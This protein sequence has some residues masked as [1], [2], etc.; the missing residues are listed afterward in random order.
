MMQQWY[1]CPKC[2]QYVQYATNPCPYCGCPMTWGQTQTTQIS[3]D[4]VKTNIRKGE[5][6]SR[7]IGIETPIILRPHEELRIAIPQ[8]NLIESRS[9][10]N[11]KALYGGPSI[12]IAKGLSLRLGGASARSESHD[13]LKTIDTGI[14]TLTTQRV[15]FSGTRQTITIPL[16]K[17]LALEP[18]SLKS[19][20]GVGIRKDDVSKMQYFT[21]SKQI[22]NAFTLNFNVG[23]QQISDTFSGQWLIWM[24]EGAMH[25]NQNT[26]AND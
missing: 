26:K 11:T 25:E 14:F 7:V 1:K 16:V 3:L 8:F 6:F 18:V 13:E 12:R 10:R 5:W 21:C 24:I 23:G 19:D 9:I 15:I 17:I 4:D 2:Q 20:E 22:F